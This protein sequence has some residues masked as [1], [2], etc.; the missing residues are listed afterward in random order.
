[1]ST[2]P[3]H[4]QQPHRPGQPQRPP[5]PQPPRGQPVERP[6]ARDTSKDHLAAPDIHVGDPEAA[7]RGAKS[8]P[9]RPL[10]PEMQAPPIEAE[11][12]L[13]KGESYWIVGH[14]EVPAPRKAKIIRLSNEPGK[15]VGVEF[16]EPIGGVDGEGQTWGLVHTCDNRGKPGHCLYVR[17]D[18][19]LDEKAM[20]TFKARQ[21]ERKA[22]DSQW[23]DFDEITVG[24]QHSQPVTPMMEGRERMA[25]G[26]DDVGTL[27]LGKGK[28]KDED[29][30]EDEDEDK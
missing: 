10:A 9:V 18:Q 1:M 11:R 26:K 30:D 28:G 3:R 13:R 19:V 20:Q 12:K 23:E 24:P 27:D 4:P 15:A 5:A 6:V 29:E 7:G 21:A 2:G 8:R 17:A 25:I 16:D 22:E 14:E